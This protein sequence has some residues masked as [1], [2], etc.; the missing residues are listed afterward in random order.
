MGL[1]PLAD[2]CTAHGFTV[3]HDD[4][5]TE[6]QIDGPG[7]HPIKSLYVA[8]MNPRDGS[9]SYTIGGDEHPAIR[10]AGTVASSR[11]TAQGD[12]AKRSTL[13]ELQ[14]IVAAF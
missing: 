13:K 8:Q 1:K 3:W 10:W 9:V 12:H 4:E 5:Y 2:W 11:F 7:E 6:V 14:E